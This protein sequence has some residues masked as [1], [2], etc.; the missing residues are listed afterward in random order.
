ME[1]YWCF[2]CFSI[3]QGKSFRRSTEPKVTGSNPVGYAEK[4]WQNADNGR[5]LTLNLRCGKTSLLDVFTQPE[6]FIMPRLR[7]R[8]PKLCFYPN[9][10]YIV[11][12]AGRRI[13]LGRDRDEAEERYRQIIAEL[14]LQPTLPIRE[15]VG[16]RS[17]GIAVRFPG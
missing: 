5:E 9:E 15:A 2:E 4:T 1:N 14:N 10:G 7:N 6:V 8:Q 16:L 3:G 12:C 13:R 17:N 11:F